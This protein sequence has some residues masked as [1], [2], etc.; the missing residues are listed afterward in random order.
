M[1]Y[2]ISA[3]H[4]RN[5]GPDAVEVHLTKEGIRDLLGWQKRFAA[6]GEDAIA[7]RVA[8]PA[9]IDVCWLQ[10]GEDTEPILD[11]IEKHGLPDGPACSCS[12]CFCSA[13]WAGYDRVP[14]GDEL[15]LE[16]T[17]RYVRWQGYWE[18]FSSDN[19]DEAVSQGITYDKLRELLAGQP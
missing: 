19:D 15:S 10:D 11:R 2:F 6:L 7:L 16:I 18:A 17:S 13:P 9:S 1:I 8:V 5:G 12:N 3:V 14:A 4:G